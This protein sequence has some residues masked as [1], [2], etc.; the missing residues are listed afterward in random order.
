M[1]DWWHRGRDVTYNHETLAIMIAS[2]TAL[3]EASMNST[4]HYLQHDW[5]KELT[6]K[7]VLA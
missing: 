4:L 6:T 7:T 3:D 5:N 1:V 2:S